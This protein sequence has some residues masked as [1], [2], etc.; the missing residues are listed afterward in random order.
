MGSPDLHRPEAEVRGSNPFGRAKSSFSCGSAGE[1][2]DEPDPQ[3][4]L[5]NPFVD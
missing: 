2:P 1:L 5:L 4:I 3:R